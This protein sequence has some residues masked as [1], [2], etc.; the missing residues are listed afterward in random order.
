MA[1]MTELKLDRDA[2]IRK[3]R[4]SRNRTIFLHVSRLFESRAN[5]ERG[6][7][8]SGCIKV[9]AKQAEKWLMDAIFSDEM[10]EKVWVH[11]KFDER[12][13]FVG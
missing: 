4:A 11:I 12:F 6:Y 1:P 8:L 5:P 10:S 9:N 13:L 7:D 3:I 2:A